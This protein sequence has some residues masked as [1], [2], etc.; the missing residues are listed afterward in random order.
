MRSGQTAGGEFHTTH[1]SQ[2]VRASA[3]DSP[4]GQEAL[5]K[6][7]QAYWY[8]LY[9]YVRRRGHAPH[10]AEDLTQSFFARL[11]EKEYLKQADRDRGRFR[12]F[13]LSSL[14]HF[15]DNEWDRDKTLKRGGGY[16][17]ISWDAQPSEERYREEPFHHLTPEK[18]Y[19]R[20]WATTVLEAAL[21]ELKQA[22][23]ARGRGQ[24]FEALQIYLSGDRQA[25]PQAEVAVRLGLSESALKV[26]IHRLRRNFGKCLRAQV[27]HTVSSPDQIDDEL[28][29]ALASLS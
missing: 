6:L 23:E 14:G 19:E 13:L 7:C 9:A 4:S 1:W 3:E 28:R 24:L 18:M 17:F 20:R 26:A 27:A 5:A 8:P 25:Q 10:E 21:E 2:V 16:S 29:H 12:T 22:Y 15:L 11:L